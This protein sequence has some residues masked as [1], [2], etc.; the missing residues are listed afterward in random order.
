MEG[1]LISPNVDEQ[2][3]QMFTNLSAILESAGTGLA[4]VLTANIYLTDSA[5]Y[6]AFN[7]VYKEVRCS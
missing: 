5:D 7:E 4:R 6:A 3:K 1:K 2:A